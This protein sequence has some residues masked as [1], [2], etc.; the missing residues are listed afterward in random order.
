MGELTLKTQYVLRDE[1]QL[2]LVFKGKKERGRGEEG[3]RGGAEK[4]IK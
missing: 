3:G 4:R 1:G 2:A